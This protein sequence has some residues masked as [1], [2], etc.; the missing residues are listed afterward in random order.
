[1]PRAQMHNEVA[2]SYRLVEDD[3]YIPVC[4][5]V[6]LPKPCIVAMLLKDLLCLQ[7]KRVRGVWIAYECLH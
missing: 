6:V 3:V 7:G 4:L 2:L 5:A 1:M